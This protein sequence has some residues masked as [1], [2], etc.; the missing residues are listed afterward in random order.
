MK[1]LLRSWLR[2][3]GLRRSRDID[4]S[5]TETRADESRRECG[6][7]YDIVSPSM[8]TLGK[9]NEGKFPLKASATIK[10]NPWTLRGDLRR[11]KRRDAEPGSPY[12]VLANRQ[13][14]TKR[15][16]VV[17]SHPLS[18]V[19]PATPCTGTLDASIGPFGTHS[20][21]ALFHPSNTLFSPPHVSPHVDVPDQSHPAIVITSP[22]I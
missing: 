16:T 12:F 19:R 9:Q 13:I 18:I 21:I 22:A 10:L 1:I 11:D 2:N 6:G 4:Q 20:S 7:R 3:R 17:Q 8:W 14:T 15:S 5:V